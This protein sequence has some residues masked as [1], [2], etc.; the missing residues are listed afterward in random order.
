[1]AGYYDITSND[2]T[3][4]VRATKIADPRGA[5]GVAVWLEDAAEDALTGALTAMPFANL[6][7][8]PSAV[9]SATAY[10]IAY[11]QSAGPL[12]IVTQPVESQSVAVGANAT[13]TVVAG[14]AGTKAYQWYYEGILIDS[15]INPTAATASL[16]NS[17]VT[18]P[19]AGSYWCVITTSGNQSVTSAHSVLTVTAP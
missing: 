6:V 5:A 9:V 18:L 16:V 3:R 13:F 19:S 8:W 2:A 7:T 17:A 4:K 11:N 1:M 12:Y 14:G 10:E 15:Q